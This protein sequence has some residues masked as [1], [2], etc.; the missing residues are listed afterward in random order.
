MFQ[1]IVSPTV[2]GI[3]IIIL[4]KIPYVDMYNY[5][6]IA[7]LLTMVFFIIGLFYKQKDQVSIS[8]KS[9]GVD[10]ITNKSKNCSISYFPLII[11]IIALALI[12]I[13]LMDGI[14]F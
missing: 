14:S 13:G 11:M 7:I 12:R 8:F 1:Q 3:I 2:I 6:D 9:H 5:A 4:L 10:D